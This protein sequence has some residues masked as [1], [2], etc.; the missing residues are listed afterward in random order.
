MILYFLN[1]SIYLIFNYLLVNLPMHG[2]NH[3]SLLA[4]VFQRVNIPTRKNIVIDAK[5]SKCERNLMCHFYFF[6]GNGKVAS[7]GSMVG[8]LVMMSLDVGLG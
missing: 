4:I 5:S 1:Y 8:F 7:W 2:M 3:L 6:S